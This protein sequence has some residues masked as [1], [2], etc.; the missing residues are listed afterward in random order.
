[1]EHT[2]DRADFL[3]RLFARPRPVG[4]AIDSTSRELFDAFGS[5]A[6]SE[7]LAQANPNAWP[8]LRNGLPTSV[9]L[10]APDAPALRL[11]A[12]RPTPSGVH[13]HSVIGVTAKS[14]N[15]VDLA[16]GTIGDVDKGDGVVPYASAHID[17]V[18]SEVVVS[19]DHFHVH[20][21]AAA[22]AEVKRILLEHLREAQAIQPVSTGSR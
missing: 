8:A 11:L 5:A 22:V 9:D 4:L 1:M 16:L 13:Y 7:D 17:G 18:D 15:V 19:A 21:H 10:L 6:R 12:G 14:S 2:T 20:H 3:S